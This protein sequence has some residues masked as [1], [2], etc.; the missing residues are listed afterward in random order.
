MFK[1]INYIVLYTSQIDFHI[2]VLLM[3]WSGILYNNDI[4]LLSFLDW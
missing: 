2:C 4:K 1:H 3:G